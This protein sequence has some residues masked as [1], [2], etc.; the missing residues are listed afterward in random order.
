MLPIRPGL[1]SLW[2]ACPK[3]P[4]TFTAVPFVLYFLLPDQ[5]FYIVKNMWTYISGCVENEYKL[6][7]LP[8]NTAS[9]TFLHKSGAVR[10]AEWIFT[11]E[12]PA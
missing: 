11:M 8:N 1:T 5:R 7:L 4:A 2:L 9:E 10:S 6:P 12:E 3:W